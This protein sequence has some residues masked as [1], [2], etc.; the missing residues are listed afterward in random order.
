MKV[1]F[2]SDIHGY[3]TNLDKIKER[4]KSLECQ[5]LVVLGDLYYSDYYSRLSDNYNK[6]EVIDFLRSFGDRLVCMRGNCDSKEDILESSFK[7][8]DEILINYPIDS[9]NIYLTHGH[10]FNHNNWYEKNSILIYGHFH[11]PFIEE[12]GDNLFINPG[13]VS[14]PRGDNKPTYLFYNGKEFIIYDMD[15]NIIF[16]KK[17]D[18]KYLN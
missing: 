15:D 4:F 2:I 17:I 13:S 18:N 12:R 11:I 16:K 3:I 5:K 6:K 14:L 8:E 7:I 10:V 9:Y 1:M